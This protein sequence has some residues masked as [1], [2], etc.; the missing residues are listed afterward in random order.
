MIE[1]VIRNCLLGNGTSIKNSCDV[2][3]SN[4]QIYSCGNNNLYISDSKHILINSNLIKDNSPMRQEYTN[5]V[6]FIY[7]INNSCVS[8]RNNQIYQELTSIKKCIRINENNS[9]IY[10]YSNE[11]NHDYRDSII[12]S[13]ISTMMWLDGSNNENNV[14][15]SYIELPPNTTY[16]NCYPPVM[17]DN[18]S[19][20]NVI[21]RRIEEL[22]RYFYNENKDE[23]ARCCIVDSTK[24]L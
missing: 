16:Y 20:S 3:F 23:L 6:G 11:I 5:A 19:H 9:E 15:R 12:T 22:S 4:N 24:N 10:F 1:N 8:I 14:K 7:S 13:D 21:Q 18:R 17:D 2:I